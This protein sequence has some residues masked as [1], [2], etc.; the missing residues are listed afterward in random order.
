MKPALCVALSGLNAVDNPGPGIPVSRCLKESSRFDVRVVGLAY[1][2]VEP[3]IYMEGM[4]ERSYLMPYPLTGYINMFERLKEI[5]AETPLDLIIPLLDSELVAYIRMEEQLRTLGIATFLPTMANIE[6]RS[7]ANLALFAG[8]HGIPVPLTRVVHTAAGL[9]ATTAEFRYPLVA[10]GVF[11]DAVVCPAYADVVQAF[12][13]LSRKWGTPVILQEHIAGDEY[14][15]AAVGDGTGE[16]IGAVISKKVFITDK[17]KG[18]A[19]VAIRNDELLEFTRKVIAAL[20][21]RGA[22]EI[23]MMRTGSDGRYALLEINPRFPAWI[24]LSAGVGLN[25]PEMLVSLAL[26]DHP[27]P[28]LA[29]EPGRIFLRYSAELLIDMH[30]LEQIT[31]TSRYDVHDNAALRTPGH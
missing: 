7:K 16:T 17:G 12:S 22:L 15:I 3:G 8:Q 25:L 20:R 14:N 28:R 23:E 2:A 1:D 9:P 6:M 19:G 11:Y 4:T 29:Y 18:W 30:E 26:G 24:Y 21:W 13:S 10:K 5:H 31:A 27:E